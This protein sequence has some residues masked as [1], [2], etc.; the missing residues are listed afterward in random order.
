LKLP[1]GHALQAPSLTVNPAMHLQVALPSSDSM[2]A[3][4]MEHDDEPAREYVFFTQIKQE[5]EAETVA[6]TAQKVHSDMDVAPKMGRYL[7]PGQAI[8]GSEIFATGHAEQLEAPAMA[9]YLPISQTEQVAADTAPSCREYLPFSHPM[10]ALPESAPATPECLPAAHL[11]H[12]DSEAP[13][14]SVENLPLAQGTQLVD[15][16]LSA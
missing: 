8:H 10:H 2:L 11:T 9:A 3:P 13:P 4:Q 12:D 6:P 1:A 7:P 5:D 15:P 14:S 16:A